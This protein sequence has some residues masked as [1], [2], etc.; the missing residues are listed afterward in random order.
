MREVDEKLGAVE[1]IAWIPA[2]L[3]AAWQ[4]AVHEERAALLRKKI[5]LP[6]WKTSAI[7]NSFKLLIAGDL[8]QGK[9]LEEAI[10]RI[11]HIIMSFD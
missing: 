2:K 3:Q 9:S 7:S 8:Q 6:A 4:S 5:K 10:E 1:E 11:D